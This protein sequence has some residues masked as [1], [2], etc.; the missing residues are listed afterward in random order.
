[1]EDRPSAPT[2]REWEQEGNLSLNKE[3]VRATFSSFADVES[4][5]KVLPEH[6]TRRLPLDGPW[7]FH[8]VKRPEE[9]PVDFFKPSHDVSSW[10]EI[11]VPSSWQLQGYDVPVYS[12]QRY[13]FKRDWPRVMGEPPKEYTSYVNRNPVGSYRRNFEVP[14][15]WNGDDVF[16]R[17]DGVDSFFY[18]WINGSYVGFSK[19]SRSPAVFDITRFLKAGTNVIAA[20][21]YRFS[22][23]SYLECQ[24]MWRLSGIFRPVSLEARP[25]TRIKDFFALPDLDAGYK[26]GKLT[27]TGSLAGPE[28]ATAR[29][30]ATLHDDA[31]RVVASGGA[32]GGS[33]DFKILM[34]VKEPR[35]WSAETPSLYTLVLS[36]KNP[37]G[38]VLEHVSA[39]TGF[40]KVEIRDGVFL[41]NGRP[42]KLKGVN[43]HEN[44]PDTGHAV[45]RGQMELDILRLKQA[46]VNHVRTSHYP[47]DPYWYYLCDREGIYLQDEA[48]IESH[49]YYYGKE[50]LSHPPEWEAAHVDRVM[51]MVER[52]KNHPSVIMWSLG[53]EAGPGRNFEAAVARLRQRDLSRPT[54]YERN[55]AIVDVGSNQYPSVA[56]TWAAAKGAA[57]V[58]YPFYISEYAHIMNNALGNLAD[59]WEAIESSDRIMGA[60]IWEWCDQGLYKT[61]ERGVRHVA[62]GGDFGDQPND[63]QFIVKGVVFADR[64]PK[65]CYHEVKQVYQDIVVAAVDAAAGRVEVFN[66]FFFKDLSGLEM[67]WELTEDGAV[68]QSGV[69]QAPEAGPRAKVLV[70]VPFQTPAFKP[71]AEYFLRVGFRLKEACGWAP[72]G[73]EVAASQVP[74]PNPHPEKPAAMSAGAPLEVKQDAKAVTVRGG[75]F[76][77]V[78]DPATGFLKSYRKEDRELLS[79]GISLN[80]FRC[81]VN[82][83]IWAQNKWFD[84]GLAQLTHKAS[85]FRVERL[86]PAVRLSASVISRGTHAQRCIDF[87]G[88]LTRV[89]T[90]RELDEK[91]LSFRSLCSWTLTPDGAVAM[92]VAV[93]PAGPVIPL[94]KVGVKMELPAGLAKVT[95]FGRGPHENYPD[96]KSGAFHGRFTETV[97]G[98]FVPYAR[99]ND[100]ANRE[101]VRWISITGDE[102]GLLFAAPHGTFSAAAL[103][104]T[105]AELLAANHPPSL[106]QSRRTVLTLDAAVLGL[107]GASCGPGP[108]DRDIPSSDRAYH[109][110]IVIRPL[111]ASADP[112]ALARV[113]LPLTSP[114]AVMR[115]KK[116]L[117]IDS[118]TPGAALRYTVN[119]GETRTFTGPIPAVAG[120]VI[121]A[122]AE[123]TGHEPSARTTFTVPDDDPKSK[124]AIRYVSS[125]QREEGEAEHVLDGDPDT[126]WHTDYGL[127][128]AKHPHTLDVDL[129]ERKTFK[130]VSCLPRHDNVNG[131]IASYRIET[132]NDGEAWTTVAEGV[133]PN[134][135]AR[136][137][138]TFKKPVTARFLRLVALSE[139]NGQDFTSL[140]ELDIIP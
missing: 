84:Q 17:F 132:S 122:W 81:P 137:N 57:G 103:P 140:A 26:D 77:A 91:S 40:R 52:D 5:L 94:P 63:G 39:R 99:P 34:D 117:R 1:M 7:K 85:G 35:K 43:R 36:L 86:G 78:F 32:A 90:G 2:G 33:A 129:G 16:V 8:W 133:F 72:K 19:D 107:G 116:E 125:R 69:A 102:G 126:Y 23:G 114:A 74:V 6:S 95:W 48:N 131:R 41:V 67:T 127:T 93:M 45:T 4:A 60:A 29:V 139:V 47:N 76:S 42:V 27:V 119:G 109:L 66:K 128:L 46:N 24:D 13:L 123:K 98:M 9:R 113:G 82:N 18:L 106:P 100:M 104:F 22:D 61:D 124:F 97:A 54:H 70:E 44:F 108:L 58:K 136:Q 56:W 20:E 10:K 38:A 83:D 96:R 112:A 12:N 87:G 115:R 50:S 53:N 62:Y 79:G 120:E 135:P 28:A 25:R 121:E 37:A 68:L 71:G 111:A 101:D 59:Y 105:D 118:P 134:N 130:G 15:E 92:Q 49:G 138:V 51:S 3:P 55:N 73:H 88:N 89:E 11:P 75:G 110:S 30:A 65:P 80:A 21:V 64:T 31:G 14:A